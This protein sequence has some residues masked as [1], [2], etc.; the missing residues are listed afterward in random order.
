MKKLLAI[1]LVLGLASAASALVVNVDATGTEPYQVMK[2]ETL[3]FSLTS[4]GE[5]YSGL[6]ALPNPLEASIAGTEIPGNR[7]GLGFLLTPADIGADFWYFSAAGGPGSEPVA[8]QPHFTFTYTAEDDFSL[9]TL[10]LLN[11]DETPISGSNLTSIT[12]QNTPEPMTLGLLGLGGL[13]LRRR[14]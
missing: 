2:G 8:N 9:V 12:I 10:H 11:E 13:F 5:A 14:K 3:T 6:L 4:G 7:G 1:T